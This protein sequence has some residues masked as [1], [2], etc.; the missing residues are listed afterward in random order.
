MAGEGTPI[1]YRT[2][3]R[4]NHYL[5]ANTY[6]MEQRVGT[7][8]EN[9]LGHKF[10]Q[11]RIHNRDLQRASRRL[12]TI[13]ERIAHHQDTLIKQ[14]VNYYV[15]A[16]LIKKPGGKIDGSRMR[17]YYQIVSGMGGF[18]E[19]LR[20]KD[21]QS[22]A[23][24]YA[25]VAKTIQQRQQ[26]FDL[27][28][29]LRAFI[30]LVE[31]N[32]EAFKEFFNISAG[33]VML[34]KNN[35]PSFLM[36]F[37][38]FCIKRMVLRIEK[39]MGREY[40]NPDYEDSKEAK[41]ALY[42]KLA[43]QWNRSGINQML[44]QAFNSAFQEVKRQDSKQGRK[45]SNRRA[46][47]LYSTTDKNGKRYVNSMGLNLQ[48]KIKA[49]IP[50]FN[51]LEH[52]N[53]IMSSYWGVSGTHMGN[54]ST[55]YTKLGEWVF[56]K[57]ENKTYWK[58]LNGAIPKKG[59]DD[60]V[61]YLTKK[62]KGPNINLH[63]SDKLYGLR[64]QKGGQTSYKNLTKGFR[65]ME[66]EDVGPMQSKLSLLQKFYGPLKTNDFDTLMFSI[67]NLGKSSILS[68]PS[69]LAEVEKMLNALFS[70]FMF[71]DVMTNF[72][73]EVTITKGGGLRDIYLLNISGT[74]YTLSEMIHTFLQ[75]FNKELNKWESQDLVKM[76]LTVPSQSWVAN[77]YTGAMKI[78]GQVVQ[79]VNQ[80]EN[81]Q[82]FTP[83]HW[84]NVRDEI[85]DAT[86]LSAVRINTMKFFGGL[87]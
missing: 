4:A 87:L 21:G 65:Q 7:S 48:G 24:Y 11:A 61:W 31:K 51:V 37:R 3:A 17:V 1:W 44:G 28:R 32:P 45:R 50:N 78:G 26:S 71:N 16:G 6:L 43:A 12:H 55:R 59:K 81:R 5:L 33:K 69:Q 2:N 62:D 75:T 41:E 80:A 13:L 19:F 85:I 57:E 83:Q 63:F 8:R 72:M 52:F 77:D 14:W 86:K 23:D 54:R 10:V 27:Y 60:A 70:A 53:T 35:F 67:V 38:N 56:A 84:A 20:R 76:K 40:S 9:S 29:Q 74:C 18:S 34:Y 25:R 79:P 64:G 47:E 73:N 46:L 68:S 49:A 82:H 36:R 30:F 58:P 15:A 66:L 39:A 42:K 22:E